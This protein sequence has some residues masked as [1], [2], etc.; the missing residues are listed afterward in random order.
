MH[1]NTEYGEQPSQ[2]A[3][4]DIG[5]GYLEEHFPRLDYIKKATI[6]P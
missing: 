3:I 2:A 5:N 1:F 4:A 6:I